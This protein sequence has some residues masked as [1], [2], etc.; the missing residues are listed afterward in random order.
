M[1]MWRTFNPRIE[2][3]NVSLILTVSTK[4]GFELVCISNRFLPDRIE[5]ESLMAYQF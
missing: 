5:L 3:F 4:L 2:I 1:I